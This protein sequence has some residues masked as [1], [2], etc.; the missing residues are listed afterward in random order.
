[1][2]W[3]TVD[4]MVSTENIDPPIPDPAATFGD[5]VRDAVIQAAGRRENVERT[6]AWRKVYEMLEKHDDCLEELHVE[7]IA[8]VLPLCEVTDEAEARRLIV[9]FCKMG[10]G[11]HPLLLASE[12]WYYL[13][14]FDG[15][16]ETLMTW[17]ARF[18]AA[19]ENT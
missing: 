14:R 8:Y 9:R 1:M 11:Q 5:I 16:I 17:T 12:R 18:E 4:G 19:R 15:T 10:I 3:V 7:P 6:R 2:L 13:P